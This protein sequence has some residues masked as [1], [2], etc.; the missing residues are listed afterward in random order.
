MVCSVALVGVTY[1]FAVT[2]FAVDMP[3]QTVMMEVTCAS[4]LF[5]YTDSRYLDIFM[6]TNLTDKYYF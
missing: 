6:S 5:D 2:D 3:N 1:A 4:N